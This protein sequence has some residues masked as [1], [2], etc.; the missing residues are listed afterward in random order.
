MNRAAHKARIRERTKPWDIVVIGGGAT[1]A[2]IAMDAATRNLD[3]LLLEQAD[4]G[5]GTSSRSTKLVHG[6]VRYLRQGNLTLVRDALRER[7]IL[8][9]NA[10]HLMH[11]IPFLIPCE[12]LW[13]RIFYVMGLKLYDFLASRNCFCKST[14]VNSEKALEL[15]PSL[16]Q[17]RTTS[18]VVYH[19]GQFDD[20]RLLINMLQTAAEHHASLMN[21]ISVEGFLYNNQSKV[22]GVIAP[23]TK[24]HARNSTSRPP[25]SSMPQTRFAI[26]CDNLI[27]RSVSR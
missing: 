27:S 24:N 3:I 1:G 9:K 25:V 26:K 2:A 17:D 16:R 21:Y 19:D 6:G 7:T 22:S 15:V 23:W 5:N 8:R 18:G 12:N 11:D 10:P 14:G 13:Q 4:F 20:A